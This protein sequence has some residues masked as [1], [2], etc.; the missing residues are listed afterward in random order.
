MKITF[1]HYH[2]KET[3]IKDIEVNQKLVGIR[4][5]SL[6]IES[7]KELMDLLKYPDWCLKCV[8]FPPTF[9]EAL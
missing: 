6:I 5:E 4:V 7:K 9:S 1:R 3:I 8:N 2:T